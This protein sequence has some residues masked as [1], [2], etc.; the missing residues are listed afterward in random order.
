LNTVGIASKASDADKEIDNIE[1]DL[2]ETT[3][4]P[5]PKVGLAF[6][7]CSDGSRCSGVSTL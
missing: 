1:D 5:R 7:E 2:L 3:P 6:L 4:E